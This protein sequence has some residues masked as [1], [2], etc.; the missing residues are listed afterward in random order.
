MET[1]DSLVLSFQEK[2]TYTFQSNSGIYLMK[3]EL[4]Q[5]IP[6]GKFYNATD[7]ISEA[8]KQKKAV[9]YYPILGYWLDIGRPQDYEKAQRDIHHIDL[10]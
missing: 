3:K 8:L 9:M 1:N 4:L 6:P 2:P 5:L 10:T 7:L